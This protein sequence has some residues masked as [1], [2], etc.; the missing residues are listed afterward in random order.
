MWQQEPHI[1]VH[2]IEHVAVDP[3][4]SSICLVASGWVSSRHA[5]IHALG[6]LIAGGSQQIILTKK[7]KK[8][9]CRLMRIG[10]SRRRRLIP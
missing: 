9:V 4:C 1:R 8:K 6:S 7:I 10:G 5:R 3:T 2:L